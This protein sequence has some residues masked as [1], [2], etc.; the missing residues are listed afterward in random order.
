MQEVSM[1]HVRYNELRQLFPQ[2]DCK[3]LVFKRE[4]IQRPDVLLK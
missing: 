3:R 1:F 2:A 4:A